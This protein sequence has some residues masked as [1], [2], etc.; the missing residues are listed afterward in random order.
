MDL[1]FD[2]DIFSLIL[3]QFNIS[4]STIILIGKNQKWSNFLSSFPT[5][6]VH[7][8]DEKVELKDISS[9][10]S[11]IE[12]SSVQDQSIIESKAAMIIDPLKKQ[13]WHDA[14]INSLEV[15]IIIS[16]VCFKEQ[17]YRFVYQ[18]GDIYIYVRGD[19]ID[20]NPITRQGSSEQFTHVSRTDLNETKIADHDSCSINT[21]FLPYDFNRG[22]IKM[23]ADLEE[24]KIFESETNS[25][26]KTSLLII[27]SEAKSPSDTILLPFQ[28][29]DETKNDISKSI[30]KE[31]TFVTS[32]SPEKID[33]QIHSVESWISADINVVS[34]NTPEEIRF[35]N[36]IPLLSKI[37]F[38]INNYAPCIFTKT[39]SSPIDLMLKTC[40]FYSHSSTTAIINSDTILKFKDKSQAFDIMTSWKHALLDNAVLIFNYRNI[41]SQK[42]L[43][44]TT[45]EDIGVSENNG[46]GIFMFRSYEDIIAFPSSL[47]RL[48]M[49]WWEYF[50]MR[51]NIDTNRNIKYISDLSPFYRTKY[52]IDRL[53]YHFGMYIYMSMF[54]RINERTRGHGSHLNLYVL[55]EFENYIKIKKDR[56]SHITTYKEYREQLNETQVQNSSWVMITSINPESL[57]LSIPSITS[58]LNICEVISVNNEVDIKLLK[59][60]PQLSRVN[61]IS[62]ESDI[63]GENSN[64]S[65]ERKTKFQSSS[66]EIR[67]D[68]I[69]E[70][71]SRESKERI[72]FMVPCSSGIY[73][74]SNSH[75]SIFAEKINSLLGIDAKISSERETQTKPLN[76]DLLVEIQ[77]TFSKNIDGGNEN[78][79]NLQ[80]M[81]FRKV[82]KIPPND[83]FFSAYWHDY[84]I[85]WSLMND[86]HQFKILNDNVISCFDNDFLHG[87][88]PETQSWEFGASHFRQLSSP[89]S[90]VKI[91][92]N[93]S[94][95][96]SH[97]K[98]TIL[99]YG[100]L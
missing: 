94:E 39:D 53:E 43:D 7:R 20:N 70:V 66:S 88:I 74:T 27:S 36:K 56:N 93:N 78:Y 1:D 83:Y 46:Y 55:K 90:L 58:W 12:T 69:L 34:V 17:K 23:V 95:L 28:H 10:I 50:V 96:C 52:I 41:N 37:K 49:P 82:P 54:P 98:N 47:Y 51:I 44:Y 32:I 67:L 85:L 57:L 65:C 22:K 63:S 91:S 21:K 4:V 2:S 72:V 3:K 11:Q 29:I 59:T 81:I 77:W 35:L 79:D 40:A 45:K 26:E 18:F 9:L 62:S 33:D 30:G 5:F 8:L 42:E 60:Y 80:A 38:V 6:S 71:A 84:F 14:Q 64:A 75:Q 97:A 15:S 48:N 76:T 86:G 99:Q 87:S 25:S 68:K 92:S 31:F 19:I 24:I 13:S 89:A 100:K 16:S 73:F 61:F